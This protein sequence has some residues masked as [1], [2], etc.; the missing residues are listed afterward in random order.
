M[1]IDLAALLIGWGIQL[2]GVLS[3]GPGVALILGT[4]MA[5]GRSAALLT[6]LGIGFCAALYA[7]LTVVGLAVLLS[8]MRGLILF[9][10]L[11]GAVYL[12]WL[13]LK[14]LRRATGPLSPPVAAQVS[15]KASAATHMARGFAMQL[16]NPKAIFFWIA[17][18]AVGSLTDASAATLAIFVGGAFVISACGHGA[19]AVVLSS[20]PFRA[21]YAAGQRWIEGALGVF[22]GFA[23]FKILTSRI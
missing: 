7:F 3:P 19:W 14:A 23:S 13:A 9:V 22:F 16:A 4:A 5:S 2:T 18:A 8:E 15:A 10:K 12:A 6:A 20:A 1:N 11:F 17:V 21:L